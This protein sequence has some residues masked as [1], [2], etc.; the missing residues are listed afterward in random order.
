MRIEFLTQDDPLYVLPFFEEFLREYGDQFEI[1]AIRCSRAMG[2]R[3]RKRLAKELLML[4][5][6]LG[7]VRIVARTAASRILSK[8]PKTKSS[9]H[10]HGFE[11]LCSAF[12]VE[13]S[14]IGNPNDHDVIQA[15]REH[16][17]DIIVSVACPYILKKELLS[18]TRMGCVNIHHA[19]LPHYRGMMPTFWQLYHGEKKVGVTVHTMVD[20]I[21]EG[22]VLLRDQ[23]EVI[24]GESLDQLICRSKKHGAHCMAKALRSLITGELKTEPIIAEQGSYFTF[25]T[26]TEIRE[27]HRKGLVAI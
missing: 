25:P 15:I 24:P 7:F 27:F 2:G 20:K 16:Q 10:F 13:Y 22:D 4:Y 21:D 12:G 18:L 11:Q 26:G 1:T 9:G 5:R 8:L 19:P 3:G 17:P 6:P 23:L 14:K